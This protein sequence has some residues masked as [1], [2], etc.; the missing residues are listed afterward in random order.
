MHLKDQVDAEA[1]DQLFSIYSK[2][3]KIFDN[4]RK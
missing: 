4:A 3:L 2:N 1:L